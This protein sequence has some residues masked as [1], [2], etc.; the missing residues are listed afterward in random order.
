ML[1]CV[2]EWRSRRE[3]TKIKAVYW[4]G[5]A[6]TTSQG[7]L[8]SSLACSCARGVI[9]L[10]ALQFSCQ[11]GLPPS[12][13]PVSSGDPRL[14]GRGKPP[15][16]QPHSL[17]PSIAGRSSTNLH[18]VFTHIFF[19]FEDYSP[20]SVSHSIPEPICLMSALSHL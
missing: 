13:V 2:Y 1:T 7:I 9:P 12:K 11:T 18:L 15:S 14:R 5:G 4:G 20:E 6:T 16:L 10:T 3:T 8:Q 19:S 17:Y